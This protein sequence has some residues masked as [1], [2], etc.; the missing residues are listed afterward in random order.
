MMLQG[1]GNIPNTGQPNPTRLLWHMI[2][3]SLIWEAHLVRKSKQ[4]GVHLR[5]LV[6]RSLTT[7]SAAL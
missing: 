3:I 1:D 5:V 6:S 4:L 7:N 2:D